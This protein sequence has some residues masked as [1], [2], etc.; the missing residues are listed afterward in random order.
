MERSEVTDASELTRSQPVYS[1]VKR[2][3]DI[4][5][6][7]VALILLF[8]PMAIVA[9]CIYI[10][11]PYGSPF[12]VQ[13]RT[14]RYGKKFPCYKFRSMIVNAPELH[15]SLLNQNE[16]DGTVFKIKNDPRITRVGKFIRKTSTK[17]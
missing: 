9:M 15:D 17:L 4:V 14:G 1:F 7:F 3:F 12:F 5:C 2:V 13:M 16:M 6:S 11:D 10:D 8:I